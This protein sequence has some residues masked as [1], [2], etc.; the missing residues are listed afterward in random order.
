MVAGCPVRYVHSLGRC[1]IPAGEWKGEKIPCISE[2][3]ML[4]AGIPV[5][6]YEKL[7]T[8][9]NPMKFD[10]RAWVAL[11]KKAGMKYIVITSKHPCGFAMFHSGG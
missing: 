5:K 6:E 3:I 4:R 9:F 8:Q 1:A 2:W 7:A 11:A 10:A